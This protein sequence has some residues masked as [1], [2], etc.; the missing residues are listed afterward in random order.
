[1]ELKHTHDALEKFA[2]EATQIL[3][4]FAIEH[5]SSGNLER[6]IKYTINN[7]SLTIKISRVYQYV[8][9]GTRPHAI[10]PEWIKKWAKQKG[11]DANAVAEKIRRYGT[12]AHPNERFDWE[13]LTSNFKKKLEKEMKKDIETYIGKEIRT[14]LKN[15]KIK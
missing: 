10:N 5:R 11:F 4:E 9:E 6:S 2:K 1:M 7:T 13:V 8:T 3:K 12:N 15:A 14:N